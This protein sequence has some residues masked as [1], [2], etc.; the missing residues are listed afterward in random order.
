MPH[1]QK[2]TVVLL[3]QDNH[4]CTDIDVAVAACDVERGVDTGPL[5]PS[6]ILISSDADIASDRITTELIVKILLMFHEF[7]ERH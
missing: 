4:L 6:R 7:R 1:H 3:V 5:G 2:R